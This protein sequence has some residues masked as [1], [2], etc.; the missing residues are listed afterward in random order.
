MLHH[1]ID[2]FQQADIGGGVAANRDD[3]GVHPRR[4]AADPRVVPLASKVTHITYQEMMELA[5][6]GA[7]VLHLRCVE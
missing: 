2:L 3:V 5:A 6:A 1:E 4:D 7:K